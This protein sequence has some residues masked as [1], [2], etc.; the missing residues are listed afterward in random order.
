MDGTVA[1]GVVRVHNHGT[2]HSTAGARV[3]DSPLYARLGYS[4]A[5]F[6]DL[7]PESVDNAVVM[8]DGEGQLTH[9]TGFEFLGQFESDG[10]QVGASRASTNW[11][12][13]D[14][15]GGPDHGSGAKGAAM[16]GPEITVV[17]LTRGAV[18]LRLVRVRGAAGQARLRIGGWPVD[19]ASDCSSEV[20]PFPWGKEL[21][22]AGTWDRERPHPMGDHL[23]IPWV[24]ASGA[25]VDGDYA[26]VVGLGGKYLRDELDA[27]RLLET[28]EVEF[29]DG[30]SVDL[31]AVWDAVEPRT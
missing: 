31:A 24:G 26:A 11:I 10:V 22:D 16:P 12:T 3:T 20:R 14:P 19:T 5:T 30:T 28:G 15:D 17:S 23:T 29:A 7:E 6:P 18:E 1:D 21:D 25:A 4:T 2:D 13:V 8:V 27:M 9:R